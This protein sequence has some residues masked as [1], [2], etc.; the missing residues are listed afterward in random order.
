MQREQFYLLFD[1]TQ[2]SKLCRH[3]QPEPQQIANFGYNGPGNAQIIVERPTGFYGPLMPPV[4]AI[5]Q[6]QPITRISQDHV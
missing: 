5:G 6:R 4:F 2:K 3:I 1:F